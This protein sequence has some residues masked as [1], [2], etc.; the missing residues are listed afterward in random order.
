MSV[1]LHTGL[2]LEFLS[3]KGGYIGSSECT[4]V[5]IPHCRKS[6]VTAHILS[7]FL[8]SCECLYHVAFSWFYYDMALSE[9][10]QK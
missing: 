8:L 2:S 10:L 6:R 5:K 3:L 4:L 9:I 7:V 1:K